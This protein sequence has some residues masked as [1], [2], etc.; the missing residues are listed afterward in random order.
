LASFRAYKFGFL[1]PPDAPKV[2]LKVPF[3]VRFVS[4]VVEESSDSCPCAPFALFRGPSLGL[5]VKEVK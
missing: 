3:F 2:A 4:F 1:S 5:A